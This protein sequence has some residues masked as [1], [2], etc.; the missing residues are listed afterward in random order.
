MLVPLEEGQC[1]S[2]SPN[3]YIR[4]RRQ[5]SPPGRGR[6]E[7]FRGLAKCQAVPSEG[8]AVPCATEDPI[9]SEAEGVMSTRI[10]PPP[11]LR[12][13]RPSALLYADKPAVVA[14]DAI[15][16]RRPPNLGGEF[17]GGGQLLYYCQTNWL[18]RV[19]DSPYRYS[20]PDI[21][22]FHAITMPHKACFKSCAMPPQK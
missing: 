3:V 12:G 15:I 14:T 13:E 19:Q 21:H 18:L 16:P 7:V 20:L 10:V 17:K 5:H 2:V 8:S 11:P 4:H 6:S 22:N 1:K 9:G